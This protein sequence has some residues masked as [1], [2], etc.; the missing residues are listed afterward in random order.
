MAC[1]DES[2]IAPPATRAI[3]CCAGGGERWRNYLGV[4]KHLIVIDGTRLIDRSVRQLRARG[5]TDVVITAFDPRYEVVG[6]RRCEPVASILPGTGMGFSSG[7]WSERG[8]TV[9]LL[10]DVFFSEAAMDAV[11][12]APD[13]EII[14]LGRKRANRV[15]A[16]GEMFGVAIPRERQALLRE[17]AAKVVELRR[18]G[19][20]GR[21]MGWELYAVVNGLDP[22]VV[23][24]GPN[25]M[26][27]E[28]ETDDF[29]F[30][31]DYLAWM[32]RHRTG[33]SHR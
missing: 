6:A 9:V 2:V 17:A 28:D 20:I 27:V 31:G 16:Y 1:A 18:Q 10:G 14:W 11:L 21:M 25:W 29:D 33:V 24:P 26:D 22:T 3:L 4:P 19:M 30:P 5:V 15:K 7:F 23:S 12:G 32:K 13:D 8:R